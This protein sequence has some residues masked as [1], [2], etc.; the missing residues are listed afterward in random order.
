MAERKQLATRNSQLATRNSQLETRNSQPATRN[1]QLPTRAPRMTLLK[2]LSRSP[3]SRTAAASYV[4]FASTAIWGLVTIPIAVA[5]LDPV[6][7]GLWTVVNAFLHYLVWVDL[8]VGPATGRLMADSVAKR[9][10]PEIN[11][12]WT[13]TRAVLVVQ[14]LVVIAIGASLTPLILHFLNIPTEL[15]SDARWLLIGGILITG[16]SL[17]MR[18]APGLLTAQNRFYW[19]PF[20]Q[21]FTPWINLL[22]FFLMLHQGLGLKAYIWAMAAGQASTWIAY[23]SLILTGPDRPRIA[24][25]GINRERFGRLFKLS[26]NMS[27][28]G[29]SDTIFNSLPAILIA[30]LG[31]LSTVPIYNFSWKGPMLGAGLV[32]RTYQSFYPSLQRL[33]VTGK[34]DEFLAKHRS[35]GMLTLGIS[36]IAAGVVLSF[37]NLMVQALAGDKFFAG[38]AVNTAFALAMITIPISGLFRILLPI[39]GDLGKLSLVSLSQLG[40]FT[41]G[42]LALWPTSGLVGIGF[43]F[44][45][46][47]LLKGSYGYFRGTANCGY[48]RHSISKDVAI[49]TLCAITLVTLCG[50]IGS[51]MP[52]HGGMVLTIPGRELTVPPLTTLAVNAI[53]TAFGLFLVM[54]SA[55]KIL[56]VSR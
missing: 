33:H 8:G 32:Q 1:Q 11:R 14:G 10:Q 13:A 19:V 50:A 29:L 46:T 41:I 4:A 28:S 47:P 9:D 34:R 22:V 7:L 53:P 55:R 40:F 16:L 15:L 2:R 36:L 45:A 38:P 43:A 42:A 24:I 37:N 17:P 44:A 6:E 56:H 54:H 3:A 39:S 35:V 18:G 31:G 5:F 26:G 48:P 12:W 27:V 52:W 30:R 20:I 23:S 49:A 21:I 25:A 51:L